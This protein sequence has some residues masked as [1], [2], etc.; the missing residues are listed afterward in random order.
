MGISW[1]KDNMCMVESA[2]ELENL[3]KSVSEAAAAEVEA[4]VCF[5]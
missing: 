1:M 2:Q 4:P 5:L 3:A